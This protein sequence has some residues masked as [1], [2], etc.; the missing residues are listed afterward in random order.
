MIDHLAEIGADVAVEGVSEIV[1]IA[2]VAEGVFEAIE[3]EVAAVMVEEVS[4]AV[5]L[6]CNSNIIA[7]QHVK[8]TLIFKV[9][10]LA[11]VSMDLEVAAADSVQMVLMA[12]AE[13]VAPVDSAVAVVLA[14]LRNL[15]QSLKSNL[16]FQ[17][18]LQ[19]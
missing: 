11:V 13:V 6:L 5:S 2:A 8:V 15:L 12:S 4:A 1:T 14:L 19:K 18:H 16:Q 10:D 7:L 9:A 17:L 3:E